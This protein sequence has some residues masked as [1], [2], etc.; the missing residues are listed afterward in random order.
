MESKPLGQGAAGEVYKANHKTNVGLMAAIKVCKTEALDQKSELQEVNVWK[1]L[2][3]PHVVR[4]YSYKKTKDKLYLITEFMEGGEL[5]DAI[6]SKGEDDPEGY[7]EKWAQD[8]AEDVALAL[9]YLHK[10]N[11]VHRDLKPENLL[12]KTKAKDSV[13]V[14]IADFGFAQIL[15][16][17]HKKL[18]ERLGTPGYAAPEI[19]Q[20]RAYGTEAD[21]WSFGVILYILLCGYPPFDSEDEDEM[22]RNICLG[23]YDFDEEDWSQIS[24]SAK[25]LVNKCLTVDQKNRYTADQIL[26]HPWMKLSLQDAKHNAKVVSRL[27][28]Y[29]AKKRWKKAGHSI[30]ASVRMRLSLGKKSPST[31]KS[32]LAKLKEIDLKELDEKRKDDDTADAATKAP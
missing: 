23:V 11:V 3:H 8:I 29:Q 16:E 30:R 20:D 5:F 14:K 15:D 21:I 17:K 9:Q 19:L 7:S 4:L 31:T 10:N 28:K 32:M 22:D 18:H 6:V 13:E 26:Q 25:D 27:K 24:P 2:L 12:L 1:N